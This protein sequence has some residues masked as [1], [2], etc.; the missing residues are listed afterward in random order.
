[1]SSVSEWRFP[2][3]LF[4]RMLKTEICWRIPIPLSRPAMANLGKDIHS[5]VHDLHQ[6]P[7]LKLS[8]VGARYQLTK[9]VQTSAWFKGTADDRRALA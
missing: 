2:E 7:W 6:R 8:S 5:R 9:A 1:M 3:F 4:I